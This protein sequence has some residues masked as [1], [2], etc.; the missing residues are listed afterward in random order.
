M[1]AEHRELANRLFAT[2]TA[3]LEDAS[4]LAV[5]GQSSRRGAAALAAHGRRLQATL[6][7]ISILIEAAVIVAAVSAAGRGRPRRKRPR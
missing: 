2:A 3:R 4:E 5:D 7:D 1:E 6:R